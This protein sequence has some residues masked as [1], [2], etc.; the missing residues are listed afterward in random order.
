MNTDLAVVELTP[1][2]LRHFLFPAVQLNRD[3]IDD[4]LVR[5]ALIYRRRFISAAVT[6]SR[7]LSKRLRFSAN[8]AT[9]TALSS[10]I[11]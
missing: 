11:C 9:L 7:S 10:A 2:A 6:T 3:L 8:A 5:G 4:M 1:P